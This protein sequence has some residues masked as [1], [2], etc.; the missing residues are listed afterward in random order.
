MREFVFEIE[1]ERGRDLVMDVFI[2]HPQALSKTVACS[3][4]TESAWRLDRI[5]GP[6]A[7]LS[8]LEELLLD[9]ER[10]AEC[11]SGDC[12]VTKHA[13]TLARTST[14]L[15]VYRHRHEVAD[16]H[17][18]PYLAA[19][20]LGDGPFYEATRREGRYE[21]RVLM[22]DGMAVGQLFDAIEDQLPAGLSVSLTHLR[23]PTHWADE[24]LTAVDIPYEQRVALELAVESGYYETP[25]AIDLASLADRLDVPR[26]T[27]QYR[28]RRA[29]AWVTTHFV[30]ECL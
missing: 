13:E 7:A 5:T 30:E 2:E 21:W 23:R 3:V 4:A 16:C 25:R 6:E 26:S 20:H 8:R 22:P 19:E 27:F 9:P 28:L 15:T 18:L 11:A 17:S 24:P 10:C 1:Y 29:E 14:H 12:R